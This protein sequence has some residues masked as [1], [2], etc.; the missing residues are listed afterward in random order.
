LQAHDPLMP[1]IGN[2][3]LNW[4][5]RITGFFNGLHFCRLLILWIKSLS[6]VYY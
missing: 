4:L 2:W 6:S 5:R 3:L 1:R